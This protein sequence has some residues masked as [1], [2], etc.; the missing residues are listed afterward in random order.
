MEQDNTAKKI[1]QDFFYT[2]LNLVDK[3]EI[4]KLTKQLKSLHPFKSKSKA[5]NIDLG[6]LIIETVC[7]YYDVKF[8]N[9]VVKRNDGKDNNA[10]IMICYFLNKYGLYTQADI[11]VQI[12]KDRSLVNKNIKKIYDLQYGFNNNEALINQLKVLDYKIN[13][14]ISNN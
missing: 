7:Q 6:A 11:G 8:E 4:D 10:V 13:K 12:N 2:L 9:L 5:V 3:V 14:I 1:V